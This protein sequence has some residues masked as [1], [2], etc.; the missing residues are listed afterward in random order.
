MAREKWKRQGFGGNVPQG[1]GSRQ[2]ALNALFSVCVLGGNLAEDPV[3]EHESREV[4]AV[5]AARID[6]DR[7][8]TPADLAARAVSVNDIFGAVPEIG[9]RYAIGGFGTLG[10]IA[11]LVD[12]LDMGDDIGRLFPPW[13]VWKKSSMHDDCVVGG[14]FDG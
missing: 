10:G 14:K 13:D 6:P 12:H 1:E 5:D 8:G 4:S 2:A 7:V 3:G 11:L 9:P